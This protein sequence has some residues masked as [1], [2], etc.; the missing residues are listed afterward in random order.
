MLLMMSDEC[1]LLKR[2]ERGEYGIDGGCR[3]RSGG[4]RLGG[5]TDHQLMMHGY[6]NL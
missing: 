3:R 2:I 6:C 1:R 4:H 5:G